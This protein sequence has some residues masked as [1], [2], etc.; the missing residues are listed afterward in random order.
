MTDRRDA[1]VGSA[2][3]QQARRRRPVLLAVFALSLAAAFIGFL[4]LG[5]W[6]VQ[7]MA[8]KHELIARV[9]ARIEAAPVA[10]PARGQWPQVG[11]ERDGYRRVRL[12]GQFLADKEVRSQAVTA[13][14]AGAWILVPLRT[15]AGD[16]VLVNRGFVPAQAQAAAAPAGPVEIEGLLRMSEPKGGFLRSNDPG[17]E[18][19]YS[20]DVAAILRAR[21]L[22]ADAS[23]PY[24]VDAAK[25][26]SSDAW[27]RGG[28][29]VVKFR[30]HHLSYA[31]TWFG[32]AALTLV[33]GY[34]LF[35]SER[36][37][38][39]DRAQRGGSPG[40]ASPIQSP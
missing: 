10:P 19:W 5:V 24:F 14:G 30:D 3:V 40:H 22:P 21:G 2:R 34:L 38:R 27:P 6:Q 13:L 20:R 32:L 33:A 29:T 11:E 8:W 4:A 17:Q 39:Q 31:L 18:R 37:L 25:D 28:L 12:S 36:C 1:A 9:E 35:A 26:P 16:Y 23:A 15:D 7:R